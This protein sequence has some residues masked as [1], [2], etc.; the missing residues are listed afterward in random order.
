MKSDFACNGGHADTVA[1]AG[2][3][4]HHMLQQ[5]AVAG[6]AEG[7]EAQR[8]QQGNGA[9]AHREDV[10]NN[11]ADARCRALMRLHSGRVIVALHLHHDAQ[12]LI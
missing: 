3:A 12:P 4:L 2:D 7:S 10:A 1:V 8:V 11:P 5:I 9:C 6:F